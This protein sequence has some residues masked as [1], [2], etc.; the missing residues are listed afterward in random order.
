MRCGIGCLVGQRPH[1]SSRAG[2]KQGR[3]TGGN[4]R[5]YG[6]VWASGPTS[7]RS[8][9]AIRYSNRGGEELGV[10][11]YGLGD[12]DTRST[13]GRGDPEVSAHMIASTPKRESLDVRVLQRDML[14]T[15]R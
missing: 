13:R 8:T 5:W 10:T 3:L 14:S 12:A 7:S 11:P 1:A 6:R 15:H 4:P 9:H 2:A